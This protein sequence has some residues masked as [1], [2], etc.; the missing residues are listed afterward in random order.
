M[1]FKFANFSFKIEILVIIQ[2]VT[3][4]FVNVFYGDRGELVN[5]SL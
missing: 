3:E 5:F 4:F 2:E 1:R